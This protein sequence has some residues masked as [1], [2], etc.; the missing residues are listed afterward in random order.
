VVIVMTSTTPPNC[1]FVGPVL[2]RTKRTTEAVRYIALA[3]S[4]EVRSYCPIAPDG[5]VTSV[6]KHKKK[7]DGV[8]TVH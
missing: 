1:S 5:W 2:T 7:D 4:V 3:I 6:I 8:S